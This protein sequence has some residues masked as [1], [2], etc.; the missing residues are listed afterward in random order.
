MA[1]AARFQCNV[2][3]IENR[4][5]I[6]RA[7]NPLTTVLVVRGEFLAQLGVQNLSFEMLSCQ[8][9]ADLSLR[10]IH[11]RSSKAFFPFIMDLGSELTIGVRV[12]FE[13]F[14]FCIGESILT[15]RQNV[16]C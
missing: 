11:E 9:Y 16:V 15:P 14:E 13:T 8:L 7:Q 3:T 12:R 5:V 4:V 2:F 1:D 6:V 10:R